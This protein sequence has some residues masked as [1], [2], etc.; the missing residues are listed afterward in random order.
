M[1]LSRALGKQLLG[2]VVVK[3][4]TRG[5]SPQRCFRCVLATSQDV[6]LP[7]LSL[8]RRL[9]RVLAALMP[10]QFCLRQRRA[11]I[12]P[13]EES[14]AELSSYVLPDRDRRA[15]GAKKSPARGDGRPRAR[16]HSHPRRRFEIAPTYFSDRIE[17]RTA[18]EFDKSDLA[19]KT[20][21][22]PA[23][24]RRPWTARPSTRRSAPS[25]SSSR[26]SGRPCRAGTYRSPRCSAGRG[27]TTYNP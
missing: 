10:R 4:L 2:S 3:G 9:L 12:S 25:A 17:T 1:G 19:G 22:T 8:L 7:L 23:T 24:R 21:T 15:K 6:L 18:A 13:Y 11:A 5:A 14:W 26:P 27:A 16:S 20:P